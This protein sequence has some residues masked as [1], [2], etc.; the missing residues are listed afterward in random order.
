MNGP[1]I[2]VHALRGFQ[3]TVAGK[4]GWYGCCISVL[5][6]AAYKGK[7]KWTRDSAIS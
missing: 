5:H 4:K 1:F 6:I 7:D 3:A 2:L